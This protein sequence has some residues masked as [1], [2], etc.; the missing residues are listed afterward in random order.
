MLRDETKIYV[1][2]GDGGPGRWEALFLDNI[3]R[4]ANGEPLLQEVDPADII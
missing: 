3:A 2:A 4:F 1:K